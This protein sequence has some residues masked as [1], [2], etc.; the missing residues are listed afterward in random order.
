MKIIT[1]TPNKSLQRT[2][3]RQPLS[4]GVMCSKNKRQMSNGNK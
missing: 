1:K 2:V 4:L 3:Y